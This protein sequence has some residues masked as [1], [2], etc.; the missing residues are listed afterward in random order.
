MTRPAVQPDP[1][2]V[3]ARRQAG[4]F[5]AQDK[6][7]RSD[8]RQ[9][10]HEHPS[11]SFDF[12][13][14]G[15]GSGVCG[16]ERVDSVPGAVEFFPAGVRHNFACAGTGIRTLHIVIPAEV[17]EQA[18]VR[19][20]ATPATLAP[21]VFGKACLCAL[22]AAHEPGETGT[23]D[24]EAAVHELIAL[25]ASCPWGRGGSVH[26]RRAAG[27]LADRATEGVS[28][29]ELADAVGVNR[30]HLARE[31][32]RAHGCSPGEY[33]RRLRLRKA[34]GVLAAEPGEPI[35]RVALACGFVDQAHL[36][37]HFRRVFGLTPA[38][39]RALL[40]A[41]DAA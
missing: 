16:R 41:G 21:E 22:R 39:Y 26:A 34:S 18:R 11:A 23:L 3:L 6:D 25:L 14:R 28:L 19:P 4:A 8:F 33:Q 36:T 17:L 9:G 15:G 27:V 1:V 12:V 7:Y 32:R 31:F 5:I 37:N 38:R 40:N 10:W 30:G 20:G 13:L 2:R 35:A 29:D 24:L